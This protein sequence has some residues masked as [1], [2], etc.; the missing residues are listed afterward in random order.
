[1]YSRGKPAYNNSH[2]KRQALYF[3]MHLHPSECG[4]LATSWSP[5]GHVSK[6]WV[7]YRMLVSLMKDHCDSTDLLYF[8][9][10]ILLYVTFQKSP[11]FGPSCEFFLFFTLTRHSSLCLCVCVVP[12]SASSEV[13]TNQRRKMY[14]KLSL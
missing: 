13:L 14:S 9:C 8:P 5:L 7:G 11:L 2:L 6:L 1:M 12:C 10:I 4:L 3:R